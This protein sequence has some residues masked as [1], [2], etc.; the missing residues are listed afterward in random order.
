MVIIACYSMASTSSAA[1]T[2]THP[3]YWS[4]TTTLAQASCSC[5][6]HAHSLSTV[7]CCVL[8]HVSQITFGLQVPKGARQAQKHHLQSHQLADAALDVSA[9]LCRTWGDYWQAWGLFQLPVNDEDAETSH[10]VQDPAAEH[11]RI[12]KSPALASAVVL[13]VFRAQ[14]C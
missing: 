8:L 5:G 10:R 1:D 9:A 14:L 12:C 7:S 11:V 3:R 6:P 2:S 4:S 13:S